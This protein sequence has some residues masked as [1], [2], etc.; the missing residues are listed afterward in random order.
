M[1]VCVD[2][3]IA[4]CLYYIIIDTSPAQYDFPWGAQDMESIC[5]RGDE[6]WRQLVDGVGRDGSMLKVHGCGTHNY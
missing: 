1:C 6:E 4:V 2:S 5:N 3:F